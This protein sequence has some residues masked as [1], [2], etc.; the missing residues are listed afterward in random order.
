M[1]LDY[2]PVMNRMSVHE[3]QVMSANDDEYSSIFSAKQTSTL[4]DAVLLLKTWLDGRR[5]L[6]TSDS[7][8]LCAWMGLIAQLLQEGVIVSN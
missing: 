2:S 1:N 4:V 6:A 8:P 5:L 7:L 3:D